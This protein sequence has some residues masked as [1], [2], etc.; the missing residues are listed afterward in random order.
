MFNFI[1]NDAEW[2]GVSS[3]LKMHTDTVGKLWQNENWVEGETRGGGK[4][5]INDN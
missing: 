4:K 1:F 3:F 2:F 5:D